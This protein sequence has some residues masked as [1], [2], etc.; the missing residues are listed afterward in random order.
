MRLE[1]LDEDF[2]IPAAD[3]DQAPRTHTA[4]LASAGLFGWRD[5]CPFTRR[6]RV[7]LHPGG[8]Q[9]AAER[10]GARDRRRRGGPVYAR[11]AAEHRHRAP[12]FEGDAVS[13]RWR[14]PGRRRS[15]VR[16]GDLT[17][18][19]TRERNQSY[20]HETLNVIR[21]AAGAGRAG[22]H[23]KDRRG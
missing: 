23:K 9:E 1:R 19:L 16:Q 7:A 17:R 15:Q 22:H 8:R 6:R 11:A 12:L 3:L 21:P 14:G 18:D 13:S 2:V 20:D 5:A 4:R 10:M